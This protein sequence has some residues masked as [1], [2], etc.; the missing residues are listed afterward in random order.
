MSGYYDDPEQTKEKIR[1]G[2]LYTGDLGIVDKDGYI[3]ITGRATEMIITGAF[4][5]FPKEIENKILD[6]PGVVSVSVFGVPD[7]KYGEVPMAHIILEKGTEVNP[8]DI[9]AFCKEKMAAYKVPKYIE[10]VKEF[11]MNPGG[12]VQKFKQQEMA[13]NKLGLIF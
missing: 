9:K 4:N 3:K 12:K 7:K 5:V 13:A 6:Y 2:W 1:D 11:P 8:G 10:F